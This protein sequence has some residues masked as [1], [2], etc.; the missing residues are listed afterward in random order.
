M[1]FV[2]ADPSLLDHETND[3]FRRNLRV[4]TDRLTEGNTHY[5]YDHLEDIG[6]RAE[7]VERRLESGEIVDPRSVGGGGRKGVTDDQRSLDSF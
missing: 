5:P 2:L 6:Q 1:T 7:W 4:V 3:I